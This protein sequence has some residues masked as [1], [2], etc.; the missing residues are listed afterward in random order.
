M[1]RIGHFAKLGQVSVK[2]LRY[3]D[4]RGLLAP[5]HTDAATGYRYYSVEQLPRL[6]RILALK[7]MG[8]SLEQIAS[9][10]DEGLPAAQL[11]G[12]LRLKQVELQQRIHEEQARLAQVEARLQQIEQ[13]GTVSSYDVVLKQVEP[14]LV[15]A[16]REPVAAF[17][18]VGRLTEEIY[19]YLQPFDVA[20]IDGALWYAAED[21]RQGIDA[22]GVVF[23]ESAVPPTRRINVY[24]LPGVDLVACVIHHGAYATFSQAYTALGSWIEANGYTIS[25]PIRE[26]YL[27]GGPDQHDE[28]Y[29]T[30]IQFPV[31]RILL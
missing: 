30:E 28:S 1:F 18:E 19:A 14:R 7:E 5:L 26:L 9:L 4:E 10:L 8:L 6:N 12:M 2:T 22:E 16:I 29:V 31:T 17:A 24:P 27:R 15:A 11:R 23:I 20:G 25:G 3:Y 13:E 21:P